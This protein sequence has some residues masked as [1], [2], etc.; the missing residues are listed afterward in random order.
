MRSSSVSKTHNCRAPHGWASFVD[1]RQP[2]LNNRI[3]LS[4]MPS[5]AGM[6]IFPSVENSFLS[7][8]CAPRLRGF[9]FQSFDPHKAVSSCS[10]P[11]SPASAHA[12]MKVSSSLQSAHRIAVFPSMSVF[13]PSAFRLDPPILPLRENRLKPQRPIEMVCHG[14]APIYV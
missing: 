7:M 5:F 3:R 10:N 13:P 4:V 6:A 11:K 9:F 1:K 14:V 2:D 8:V 12:S